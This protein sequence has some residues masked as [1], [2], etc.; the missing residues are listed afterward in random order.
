MSKIDLLLVSFV[1]I[2]AAVKRGNFAYMALSMN[3]RCIL[4]LLTTLMIWIK[5][6]NFPVKYQESSIGFENLACLQPIEKRCK[7]PI[8]KAKHIHH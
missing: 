5:P 4:G 1:S 2:K 7:Q 8:S 6:R 3:P